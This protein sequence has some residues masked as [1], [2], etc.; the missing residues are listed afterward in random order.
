MITDSQIKSAIKETQKGRLRVELRDD[1][2]RGAGRLALIVRRLERHTACE[3]Y[4]LYHRGENRRLTKIG[5][6]PSLSLAD[7]RKLF[8]EEYAPAILAGALP[9]NRFARAQHKR[10]PDISVRSLFVAYVEH[11]KR[12]GKGSWYQAA[13]ILLKREDNALEAL[14]GDRPARFVEPKE[15]VAYLAAIHAK[16]V[17]AMAHNA[18]AYI[19]AAFA[20][21]MKS[22]HSYT[23]QAPGGRWGVSANPV[24]AIPT[25]LDALRVGDR[26]LTPLEFRIFWEWLTL[27][28][29]RSD[30]APALQLIMATGQRVQE[31]LRISDGGY[32]RREHLV[33]WDTT[34]NKLPHSIPLPAVAIDIL[35]RLSPNCFGLLFPHRFDASQHA[36]YTGPNKVCAVYI[37]ETG[38][39]PFTPRD[40]RRTW[41][42]LAGRAGISKELRDRLQNHIRRND[43]SSRHYDRYDY[44]PERRAAMRLWDS[45]LERVLA[46]ELDSESGLP[47]RDRRAIAA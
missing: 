22:E 7:A 12:S 39:C 16:G 29:A 35:D 28:P 2:E 25:D 15:I 23:Q 10:N 34:K 13:R 20:F 1:G 6:Y 47:A 26:Y 14:G 11:L 9:K 5:T 46:G 41:K 19:S 33:Y 4:A 43:V 27:N 24:A 45:F 32:D 44:L 36:L 31:V 18:R 17:A 40:L 42:T 8:R 3:W 38:A 21:A 30:M 37:S